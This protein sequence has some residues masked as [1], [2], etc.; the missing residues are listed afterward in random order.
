MRLYYYSDLHLEMRK[1]R[2][3][4]HNNLHKI[5]VDKDN[6]ILILAGDV[7]YLDKNFANDSILKMFCEKFSN[8]YMICGNHEFYCRNDNIAILETSF[9]RDY[10]Y[11][12]VVNNCSIKI[13][14]YNLIF[15]TMLSQVQ[16]SNTFWVARALNDFHQINYNSK[17]LTVDDYNI[18]NDKCIGY[19]K[20][21]LEQS[22]TDK[23][24]IITHHL[25]TYLLVADKYRGSVINE[26]FYVELHD[27]IFENTDKIKYWI[28]GHS[29]TNK[30][31]EIKNTKLI[32]NQFGYAHNAVDG[33]G[34]E[35]NKY[36]ELE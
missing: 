3:K 1:N 30:D 14:D 33:Y 12:K 16:P 18:I 23:N 25:P 10:G 8:A 36:I 17:T 20:I 34:F 2:E 19:I 13:N 6:S 21:F 29:H 31:I 35:Y 28:F 4:F 26:A 7:S 24:I 22:K 32:C 15:S 5:I 11:L 9:E 27:Y